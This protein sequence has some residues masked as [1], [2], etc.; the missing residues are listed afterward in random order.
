MRLY[1]DVVDINEEII[2]T[3]LRNEFFKENKPNQ[4]IKYSNILI[5]N[6]EGKILLPKRNSNEKIFP[7]CYDFSCGKTLRTKENYEEAAIK[8]IKEELGIEI[9]NMELIG[10]L[11]PNEGVSGFMKIYKIINNCNEINSANSDFQKLEWFEIKE[12][13]NLINKNPK[14]FKSDL[15]PVMKWYLKNNIKIK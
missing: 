5:F 14:E 1:V 3:K 10:K 7:N 6:K 4:Y 2:E 11:S 12:I 9:K 8:A 15:L 13:I